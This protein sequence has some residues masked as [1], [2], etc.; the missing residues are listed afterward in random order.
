[1]KVSQ[2]AAQLYTVREFAKTPPDIARTLKKVRKIGYPAV[3]VSGLGPIDDA[4]L[5]NM[6]K[7]EG[8][9]CCATH[10][11]NI[12]TEPAK[13]AEHLRRLGCRYTAVPHPGSTKLD[14][15]ADVRTFA[16]RLDEAGR[17]LLEG[18]CSLAYHNHNIEFRRYDGRVML[19]LL[20]SETDPRHLKAEIDTYWVQ[21]G[22][23]DPVEWCRRL[24]GR[25]PMIHLKDYGTSADGKPVFAEVGH[26][27]LDWPRI[28]PAAQEAGCEWFIVEQ[29]TCPGDPF[30]SLKLS[31]EYLK[32][33]FCNG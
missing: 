17:I 22:G 8:L 23:G 7:G 33:N 2:I 30:E 21:Y 12:L 1:L 14:D 10:E 3:Q 29:D 26:G 28:I 27:N 9:R 6:L 16:R 18:G 19:E 32:E 11:G 20:Y 4:E 25:L 31:F 5:A 13:V 24:K 15:V